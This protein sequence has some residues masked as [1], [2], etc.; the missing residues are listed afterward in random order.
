MFCDGGIR[1]LRSRRCDGGRE[2]GAQ[3]LWYR[4]RQDEVDQVQMQMQ[5][6]TTVP[7]SR[8]LCKRYV[9]MRASRGRPPNFLDIVLVV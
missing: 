4:G 9:C 1:G 7:R 2:Y 8:V 3:R 6:L 5:I